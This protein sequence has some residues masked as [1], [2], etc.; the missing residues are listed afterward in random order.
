ML[1]DTIIAA[2]WVI[3]I[4]PKNTILSE[5]SIVIQNGRI[6]DI[7]PTATALQQFQARQLYELK[8]SVVMPGF[9][10]L[11]TH[12]AMNLLRGLGADLALMDWLNTA[13]WPAEGKLMSPE[14]VREGA[15]L[16]GTEMALSGITCASDHYFFPEE[17]AQGLRSSGLRCAVSG[18]VIGFPS[19]WAQNDNE[20]LEKSEA[21]IRNHEN[22]PMVHTT[23]G[24][25]APYTVND[26][27]LKACAKLSDRYGVPIHMHIN[28]TRI[29]VEN[30]LK[31]H[32]LRPLDRLKKLGLVNDRLIAV[33]NVH[34]NDSDLDLLTEAK[35][36]MCH[37][38]CSNLKLA[39]GFAPVAKALQRG[40]NLG[41]GTDGAASNDKLDMLGETRLGAMLA[42]AVAEDT[43]QA[44]VHDMLEAATLGGARALH[45][46][47]EIGSVEIGKCA[48]LI[49]VNLSLPNA[50]P[51]TNPA[52]Q[53][54]YA[55]DRSDITHTWVNG[56]LIASKQQL[57]S[58]PDEKRLHSLKKWAIKWK[59]LL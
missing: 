48:D 37:C 52:A 17:A 23:I 5:T 1:V 16:A 15:A 14:F 34:A 24:P 4:V 44:T 19:A 49:A 41:I 42:K 18:L 31:E 33:H 20:Y 8:E 51:V 46:D 38:P 27:A 47:H 56:E 13:I 59:N 29:E 22:D 43:T 7:L 54:L 53:L 55:S 6:L 50:V 3:P 11:H 12:A 10:N 39:S 9:V 2:R 58:T 25:H 26:D 30:S 32:H 35:S 57:L 40:L 21:L 45:W 28:E 36:S